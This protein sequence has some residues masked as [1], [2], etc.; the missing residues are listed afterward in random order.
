MTPEAI[1]VWR[2]LARG[3]LIGAGAAVLIVLDGEIA[4]ISGIL[5]R[6]V[7]GEVGEHGW[8]RAFPAG[9]RA[10]AL[11]LGPGPVAWQAPLWLVGIAGALVGVGT[12]V[13]NG[14][15]SGHGVCGI[16][17]LSLRSLVATLTFI[18]VAALVVVLLR[19]FAAP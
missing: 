8:R 2:S 18:L 5:G 17:N 10:P 6:T 1:P 12:R 19:A 13:G 3:A 15:T 7:R 16:A 14:C 11:V 9:L 4:G